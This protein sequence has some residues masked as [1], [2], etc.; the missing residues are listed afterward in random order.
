M[1]GDWVDDT[2]EPRPNV[3]LGDLQEGEDLKVHFQ[4]EGKAK[5]TKHG[6]ALQVPCE[7]RD[8]PDGYSDISGEEI[9][10]GDEVYIMS[11]SSRFKNALIDFA[12]LR[13]NGS[14]QGK[15]ATIQCAG[16]GFD[17]HYTVEE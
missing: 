1:A 17:R 12:G 9:G 2:E 7:V 10:E 13:N 14:L 15:L 11:S 16:T 5:E 6:D 3:G 8:A 4:G